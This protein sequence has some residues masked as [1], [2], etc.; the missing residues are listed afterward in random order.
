MLALSQGKEAW[1]RDID[2]EIWR[3]WEIWGKWEIAEEIFMKCDKMWEMWANNAGGIG[4]NIYN[5]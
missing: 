5:V 3:K 2:W 4:A 1:S